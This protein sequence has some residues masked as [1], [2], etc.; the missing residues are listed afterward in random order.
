[1]D[2]SPA[3]PTTE[4]F[5]VSSAQRGVWFAQMSAPDS[6][7]FNIAEYVEI[8]AEVDSVLFGRACAQM[9][10][11]ADAHRLA[12][13]N[14]GD[15]PRQ[16]L[17]PSLDW[18]PHYYDLSFLADP[19]RTAQ[20]WMATDLRQPFRPGCAPHFTYALLKLGRKHYYWYRRAHHLLADGASSALMVRRVAELYT[21][22]A[23]GGS[24]PLKPFPSTLTLLKME[25]A[26]RASAVF[27]HDRAFWQAKLVNRPEVVTF[28]G[29]SPLLRA[30]RSESVEC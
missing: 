10:A 15:G 29:R 6:P 13:T 26:Y 7:A 5:P 18:T 14:T 3:G 28:A 30:H 24:P 23:A 17:Q 12:F 8:A 22:L 27:A 20:S 1:V 21:V 19:E 9:V 11:E 16:W 4:I 25:E 2:L